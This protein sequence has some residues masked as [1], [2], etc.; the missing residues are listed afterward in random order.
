LEA[1]AIC[2]EEIPSGLKE[3]TVRDGTTNLFDDRATHKLS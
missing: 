1:K 2:D 3:I